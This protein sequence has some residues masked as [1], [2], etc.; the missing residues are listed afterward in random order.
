MGLKDVPGLPE[1]SSVLGQA[2]AEEPYIMGAYSSWWPPGVLSFAKEQWKTIPG[3]RVFFAG[4]EW[5]AV[6]AGYM[7]GAIHN[8]RAHGDLVTKLLQQERQ[9]NAVVV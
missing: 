5:S 4:T 1:P 2:W 6:G 3:G 9:Q 7:N 8:G